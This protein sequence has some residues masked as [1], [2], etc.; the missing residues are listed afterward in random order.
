MS[1]P[2]GM[3][4]IGAGAIAERHMQA[5][6]NL[7]GVLPRWVVSRP[8]EAARDFAKRWNFAHSA[9]SVEPALADKSVQIVL[10]AS[11]SPLH[12]GQA[13]QALQAGFGK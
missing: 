10:I 8:A 1:E 13:I 11:P 12:S 4:I 3:C 6:Q 9:T 5:Y 2:I 7:G